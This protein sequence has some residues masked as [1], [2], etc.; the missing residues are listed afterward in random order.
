MNERL[1]IADVS[2][3]PRGLSTVQF[4]APAMPSA[5]DGSSEIDNNLWTMLSIAAANFVFAANAKNVT[6]AAQ[7]F[8]SDAFVF[9][10]D[11]YAIAVLCHLPSADG[12]YIRRIHDVYD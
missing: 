11:R 9:V 2:I 3:I 4:P 7:T 5:G 12:T 10:D 1:S 6:Q 8:A